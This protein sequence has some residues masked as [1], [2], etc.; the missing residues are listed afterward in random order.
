MV[1]DVEIVRTKVQ[2][3]YRNYLT[4]ELEQIRSYL[5]AVIRKYI[6]RDSVLKDK[7]FGKGHRDH[8]RIDE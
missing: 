2:V 1:V 4:H 5:G 7:N 8:I 3:E 6:P